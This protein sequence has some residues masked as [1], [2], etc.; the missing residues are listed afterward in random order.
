[1]MT[2]KPKGLVFVSRAWLC[3]SKWEVVIHVD[4][5]SQLSNSTACF[6]DSSDRLLRPFVAPSRQAGIDPLLP[7]RKSS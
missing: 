1:M 4:P 6:G 7:F 5:G 3:K 2:E